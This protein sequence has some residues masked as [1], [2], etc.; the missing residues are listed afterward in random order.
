M[1]RRD[2]VRGAV[3][4]GQAGRLRQRR[5]A[6]RAQV[7]PTPLSPLYAFSVDSALTHSWHAHRYEGEYKDGKMSGKGTFC[8]PDGSVY[9]G[10]YKVPFFFCFF[11][12]QLIFQFTKYG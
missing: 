8:W 11:Y 4:G 9:V 1:G 2:Q 5:L 12:L 3:E 6:R 7:C 10:E